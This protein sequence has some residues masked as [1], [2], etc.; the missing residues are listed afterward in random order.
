MGRLATPG[1]GGAR[2]SNGLAVGARGLR[3]KHAI[4]GPRLTLN[5]VILDSLVTSSLRRVC[6]LCTQVNDAV[7]DLVWLAGR[8]ATRT[9]SVSANCRHDTRARSRAHSLFLSTIAKT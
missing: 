9:R 3:F 2:V 6:S 8:E 5:G 7:C 1:I 4:S